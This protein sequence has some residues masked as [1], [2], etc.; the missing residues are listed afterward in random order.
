MGLPSLHGYYACMVLRVKG[1]LPRTCRQNLLKTS[2][3]LAT[4]F[5]VKCEL[6]EKVLGS[7]GLVLVDG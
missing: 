5:S 2:F 7:G 1:A 3:S 6:F 4:A